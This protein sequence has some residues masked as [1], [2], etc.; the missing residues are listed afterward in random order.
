MKNKLL[1]VLI[2][3]TLITSLGVSAVIGQDGGGLATPDNPDP[4]VEGK[5]TFLIHADHP[6]EAI[7]V[8]FNLAYPNVEMEYIYADDHAGKFQTALAAGSGAPDLYW[9]EAE[10]VQR[11]GS[12]GALLE[13]TDLI[14]RLGADLAPGKVAEAYVAS[15]DGYFGMPGDLS[16]S[17]I[18]YRP[19]AM[20]EL[21]IEITN[22]MTY[23]EF[24]VV[25]E[26]IAAAGK[27]AVL[28]PTG[29]QFV[30][31][32]YWGWFDAQY[33]GTGPVSCDNEAVTINDEAGVKAIELIRDI[34]QTGAPLEADFW[35]PEYWEAINSGQLVL[36][37]APG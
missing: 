21:G 31:L 14:E 36:D 17:G 22:D 6:L 15:Q 5:L 25:L 4:S 8:Q 30:G 18:Y 34:Y 32:A 28:Y 20:E 12:L 37:M 3:L 13:T 33:G 23:E 24:L 16:V 27:N 10:H 9:G 29:G 11:Y 2:A 35:S 26:T 1:I 19:D 7:G